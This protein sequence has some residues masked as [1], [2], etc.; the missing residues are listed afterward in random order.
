[1]LFSLL[2]W[3]VYRRDGLTRPGLISGTFLIGYAI[4]RALVETVRAETHFVDQMPLGLT[5]GQIL[6]IPMVLFGIYIV[7]RALQRPP[8]VAPGD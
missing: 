7:R 3:L 1:M 8:V 6:S 4:A 2:A 5:Y